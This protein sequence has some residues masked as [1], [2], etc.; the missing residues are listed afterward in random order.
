MEVVFPLSQINKPVLQENSLEINKPNK[1]SMGHHIS[2]MNL[3][4]YELDRRRVC[5]DS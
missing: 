2:A 3:D 1:K 4:R 5:P